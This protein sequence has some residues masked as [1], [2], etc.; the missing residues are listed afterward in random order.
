MPMDKTQS[1]TFTISSGL[2]QL[3]YCSVLKKPLTAQEAQ[4]LV[5]H[6]QQHNAAQRITGM[7]MMDHGLV[8]Q[9]LE[10]EYDTVRA[11]WKRI[12]QDP[13]HHCIVE[14]LHRNY[15]EQRLFPD[16]SMRYASRSEML[17]IVHNARE[18]AH[19]PD[20][21]PSPWAGAMSALCILIDPE[22]ASAYAPVMRSAGL[23]AARA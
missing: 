14:L 5:A 3:A 23:M 10:G 2:Y 22:Y 13:R 19:K 1:S 17:A 8:V 4:G 12:Q 9:W 7:M 16:W 18:L 6:A 21:L 15:Q 11:L 20:G